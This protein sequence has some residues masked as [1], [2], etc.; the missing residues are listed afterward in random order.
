M[1]HNGWMTAAWIGSAFFWS[2]MILVLLIVGSVFYFFYS[3]HSRQSSKFRLREFDRSAIKSE[4]TSPSS[5]PPTLSLPGIRINGAPHEILGIP[6]FASKEE[7]RKAY[8]ELMK[9]YHPDLMGPL[10]SQA[11]KDAQKI[12]TAINDA[13]DK[14]LAGK[15]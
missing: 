7:V 4:K 11:W 15:N 6:R 8:K 10:G 5:D 3:S 1:L 2:Q 14:M 9:R 12:A 13:K